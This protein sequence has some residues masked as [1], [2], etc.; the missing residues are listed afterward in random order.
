[1]KPLVQIFAAA[2]FLSSPSLAQTA[3]VELVINGMTMTLQV[4]PTVDRDSQATQ[5]ATRMMQD[6]SAY[7]TEG[8]RRMA[9]YY[10]QSVEFYGALLSHQQVMQDRYTFVDRWPVRDYRIDPDT[11]QVGCPDLCYVIAE[12]DY[13]AEDPMSGAVSSGRSLLELALRPTDRSFV[14]AI[15]HGQILWRN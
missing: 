15:E 11:V 13:Y 12:Y 4:A 5:F 14:I 6:W 9:P 1:M 2:M 3:N 8:A 10:A 7:G